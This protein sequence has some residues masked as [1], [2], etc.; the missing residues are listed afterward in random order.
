MTECENCRE[1]VRKV[2]RVHKRELGGWSRKSV[3]LCVGCEDELGRN[4]ELKIR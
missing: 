4:G 2:G 3:Y 1:P